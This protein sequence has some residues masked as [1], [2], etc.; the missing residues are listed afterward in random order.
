[1]DND[2]RETQTTGNIRRS[3]ELPSIH[4]L[5]SDAAEALNR[6]DMTVFDLAAREDERR[7]S[8]AEL[9]PQSP[10]PRRILIIVT[11]IVASGLL[12]TAAYVGYNKY[13]VEVPPI[14]PAAPKSIVAANA[15]TALRV[16]SGDRTGLRDAISAARQ[17]RLATREL[18]YLP[19]FIENFG[20][21]AEA[22]SATDFFDIANIR[23]PGAFVERLTGT[24]GMYTLYIAEGSELAF[25]FE[26]RNDASDRLRETLHAWED[27]LRKD[28]AIITGIPSEST[29]KAPSRTVDGIT[30]TRWITRGSAG[31]DVKTL[32]AFLQA[33][34]YRAA[35]NAAE[36]FTSEDEE[37]L[38]KFQ[39]D[40]KLVCEGTADD[41]YGATGPK[42]RAALREPV[43][44][45]TTSEIPASRGSFR[46]D[47]FENTDVRVLE[48][49]GS[50]NDLYAYAIFGSKAFVIA[51]S[52]E[53]L[54]EILS[55]LIAGP[56]N[57]N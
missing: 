34:G 21:N 20:A 19:L 1:M 39:C 51:T 30:I 9:R 16:T 47:I 44:V 27:T 43:T 14:S 2:P 8:D 22:A 31:E 37:A 12:A 56:V 40:H 46:D 55:R 42:T 17:E 33:T 32:Q 18:R 35:S 36:T 4:T 7:A 15:E 53:A 3:S 48:D 57:L 24:W 52:P 10:W 13:V 38:K 50:D 11:V 29:P 25:I 26:I 45:S 49:P 6:R 28:F 54:R 41:G 23:P 5:K